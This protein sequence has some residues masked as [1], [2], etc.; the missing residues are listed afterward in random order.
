VRMVPALTIAPAEID[1][2]LTIVGEILR[3]R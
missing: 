2:G 3:Q 1:E